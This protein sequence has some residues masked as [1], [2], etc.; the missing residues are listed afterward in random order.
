M[1]FFNSGFF[2]FVT[3]FHENQD[4]SGRPNPIYRQT[5]KTEETTLDKM[6]LRPRF[7][8]YTELSA[9]EYSENIKKFLKKN[10]KE[11][12]GNV[13]TEI[14]LITVNTEQDHYWKPNLS[15]RTEMEDQRTVIRGIFG[16]SSAVWTFFMFLYFLLGIIWMVLITLWFVGEQINIQDYKWALPA[17]IVTVVL[18]LIMYAAVKI[19]QKKAKKEM[20]KL[21]SFAILSTLPFEEK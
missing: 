18:G 2:F 21:R 9:E 17:S 14:A 11:F 4:Y 1:N 15:L 6:R 10:A 13:N 20:E 12:S 19:G 8:M 5:M 3:S 16:P 7:K